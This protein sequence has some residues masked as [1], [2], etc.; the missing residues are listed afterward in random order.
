[1]TINSTIVFKRKNQQARMLF[2]WMQYT[3]IKHAKLK[4]VSDYTTLF[5]TLIKTQNYKLNVIHTPCSGLPNES[6]YFQLLHKVNS[7]QINNQL[8][9]IISPVFT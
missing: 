6:F 4:T 2:G 1:V 3:T 7:I 8:D 5:Y 9:A